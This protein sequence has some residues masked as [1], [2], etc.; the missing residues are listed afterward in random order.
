MQ[1]NVADRSGV[2]CLLCVTMR[3]VH[4][5]VLRALVFCVLSCFIESFL[6]W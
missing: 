2:E 4:V 5:L 1:Q 6:A 3:K